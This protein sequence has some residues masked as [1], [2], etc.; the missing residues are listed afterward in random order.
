[1]RRFISILLVAVL[2]GITDAHA[3]KFFKND[4]NYIG[5]R[6]GLNSSNLSF[7]G[8]DTDK[9]SLTGI[10]IG[11]VYGMLLS[12]D[13]PIYFEPGV[14]I[15][16]KGVKINHR[17]IL[18]SFQNDVEMNASEEQEQMRTRLTYLEVPFVFKYKIEEIADDLSVQPFLG[19]FL[20]V[21][22]GGKTKYYDTRE[23]LNSFRSGAFRP[24]DA[25]I[26]LGCGVAYRNLYFDLSYDWGLANVA[27]NKFSDFGYDEFDD[28]IRTRNLSFTFGLDF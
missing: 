6:L 21:G 20:A 24:F 4:E 1:M 26:R 15:S 17:Y 19:G 27:S 16:S 11:V 3:Q 23:K 28:A 10:N 13:M 2:W 22:L 9:S 8:F 14:L 25:G 18:H 5:F 12:D 7:S